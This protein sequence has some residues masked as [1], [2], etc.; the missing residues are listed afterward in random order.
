[1]IQLRAMA[2]LAVL[3][4]LGTA[5]W[6]EETPPGDAAQFLKEKGLEDYH[7]MCVKFVT[8]I[9]ERRPEAANEIIV[10]SNMPTYRKTTPGAYEPLSATLARVRVEELELVGYSKISSIAL[11]LHYIVNTDWGPMLFTLVTYRYE[12]AWHTNTVL[13]ESDAGRLID[14][15]KGA[16]RFSKS[17]VVPLKRQGKTA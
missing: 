5:A 11:S 13:W 8:A 4:V 17:I 3:V 12:N 7:A 15:L 14:R 2:F 6:A 9:M 16:I 1:M 10:S